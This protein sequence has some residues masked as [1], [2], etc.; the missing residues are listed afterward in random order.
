MDSGFITQ[1]KDK[2]GDMWYHQIVIDTINENK[3]KMYQKLLLYSNELEDRIDDINNIN[4]KISLALESAENR[5]DKAIEYAEDEIEGAKGCIYRELPEEIY[6]ECWKEIL[7]I[8]KGV[9]K[10]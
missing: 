8:L 6:I 2:N 4:E 3:D 1:M 7:D 5:L 10:K 9:D